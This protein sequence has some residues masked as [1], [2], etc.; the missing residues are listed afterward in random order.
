MSKI[1]DVKT[2][3]D[4]KTYLK[5]IKANL[6]ETKENLEL[7]INK[8]ESDPTVQSFYESGNFGKDNQERLTSLR[9]GIIKYEQSINGDGALI[10]ITETFLEEQE[11][12]LEHGAE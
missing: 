5:Y 1:M 11:Q 9:N 10:P 4:D 7:I 3:Q 6:S 12:R 8:F 2:I